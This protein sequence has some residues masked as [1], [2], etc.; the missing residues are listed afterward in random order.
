M[1]VFAK[2]LG[3]LFA[4]AVALAPSA[5]ADDVQGY[6]DALHER[7]IVNYS[8]DGTLVQAGM[9]ICDQIATGRTPMSV[10]MEVYRDTDVSI[11][12]EDAGFIVGA[13]IGGLCP[14]FAHLVQ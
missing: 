1:N 2:A 4:G 8:G 11:D 7:G 9:Y 13:A 3:L 14:E 5:Q 12:H 10:A 6:L